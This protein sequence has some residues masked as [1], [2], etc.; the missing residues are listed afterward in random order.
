MAKKQRVF[1]IIDG[2]N[3]Y[4]RLKEARVGLHNLLDFDYTALA[5]FLSGKRKVA[6]KAYYIGL[7][8][9]NPKDKKAVK[10]MANQHR[11]L[12]K[13]K[14]EKWSLFYG[15]LLKS[16]GKYHE[17]GVDVKIAVDLIVGAYENEYDT[18]ILASSDTDLLPAI[19]KVKELGKEIEYIGFGHKPS[20]GLQ[21]HATLSHLLIRDELLPF[22]KS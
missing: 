18:A 14:K 16:K 9:A 1:I 8:R 20:F 10:M 13:L 2:S 11:L 6:R 19:D 15:D 22:A 3:F 5:H 21:A 4:H 12:T 17:K 7:V